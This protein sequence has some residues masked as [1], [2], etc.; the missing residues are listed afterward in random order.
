MRK[1]K[2]PKMSAQAF[3]E[4]SF[5]LR[6]TGHNGVV[7]G[8]SIR[9][10]LM[11]A[12]SVSGIVEWDGTDVISSFVNGTGDE[13]AWGQMLLLVWSAAGPTSVRAVP[14]LGPNHWAR[15]RLT[16][17]D[18]TEPGKEFVSVW[19]TSD[20]WKAGLEVSA[21]PESATEQEIP[22]KLRSLDVGSVAVDMVARMRL[23]HSWL[24][25]ELMED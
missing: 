9:P 25:G 12:T 18:I 4:T 15:A 21:L 2:Q 14:I 8:A 11:T 24:T 10:T 19:P 13:T 17:P 23:G 7:I 1:N 5:D 22:L 20:G 16:L 3:L 6:V